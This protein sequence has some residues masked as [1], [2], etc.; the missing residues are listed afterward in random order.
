VTWTPNPAGPHTL[1]DTVAIARRYGVHIPDDVVTFEAEGLIH[2]PDAIAQYFRL[3]VIPGNMV[4]W[5]DFYNQYDK[6]PGLIR[7]G[8][9]ERRGY[10]G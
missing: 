3:N 1:E 6:I 7:R 10:R 8:A 2:D 4:N 9:G 5:S